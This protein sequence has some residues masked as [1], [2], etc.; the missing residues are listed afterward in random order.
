MKNLILCIGNEEEFSFCKQVFP[1]KLIQLV[2]PDISTEI[3]KYDTESLVGVVAFGEGA[4]LA[5][6]IHQILSGV[7]EQ[8]PVVINNPL[9]FP[10]DVVYRGNMDLFLN[11]NINTM[12]KELNKVFIKNN[13]LNNIYSFTIIFRTNFIS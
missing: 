2:A 13:I 12:R 11:G 10:E 4:V 5:F 1:D 7:G 8:I 3:L 6:M 9:F